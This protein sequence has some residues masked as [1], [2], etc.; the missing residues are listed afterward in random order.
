MGG[1]QQTPSKNAI[2]AIEGSLYSPSLGN[3]NPKLENHPKFGGGGGG[4]LKNT[5]LN[6]GRFIM[7]GDK[8]GVSKRDPLMM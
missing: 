2:P 1:L 3:A 4:N 7:G 6:N 8:F 5:S